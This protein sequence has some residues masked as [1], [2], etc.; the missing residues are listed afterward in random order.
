[1]KLILFLLI[2]SSQIS[3]ATNTL[4]GDDLILRHAESIGSNTTPSSKSVLDLTSTT[5]GLLAPRMTTVQQ[6]AIT[7]VPEGLLLFDSTLHR[8]AYYNASAWLNLS[9]LTGTETLTNKTLTT[10]TLDIISATE[11]SGVPSTPSAGTKKIYCKNDDTCYTL[12]SSGSEVALGSGSGGGGI[13]DRELITNNGAETA[14]TGFTAYADAAGIAPVDGT[15]GSPTFTWTRTTSSPITGS[16]SFLATKD[17]AN[18][19]G[20]GASYAF[21]VG[22]A[23]QAKVLQ[24]EFDYLV[25]SGAF[26]AGSA[27]VDSDIEVYIYDVTNSTLIQ[28]SSYKLLSTS[29]TINSHFT[30]NFQ[31]S[32]TGTSYRLIFHT[33][34][35]SAS[36]YTVK[37]DN[38]SVHS[39]KYTYGTPITDWITFTASISSTG[40]GSPA[41]GTNTQ[42]AM[43]RRVG[44]SMHIRWNVRQTAT[45]TTGT[46]G[47]YLLLIPGGYSIDTSKVTLDTTGANGYGIGEAH[48]KCAASSNTGGNAVIPYNST[49]LATQYSNVSG[50]LW[51]TGS[52]GCILGSSADV[53]IYLEAHIPIS[54]WSATVQM[55]DTGGD[56]RVV[57]ARVSGDPASATSGNI[58]IFPTADFDTHGAY[59]TTTGRFTCPVSGYYRV[60]VVAMTPTASIG[61]FVYKNAV[62]NVQLGTTE[63]DLGDLTSSTI[64][65][66]N[67]GDILDLRPNGTNNLD[68][69]SSMAYEK[70]GGPAT[71]AATETIAARYFASGTSIN[72]SL[73]TI[74]WT[75]KDYDTHGGMSAGTYTVP[76]VGKY[77]VSCA[78]A[79]SGTHALN[80]QTIIEIQKNGT[81]TKNVT[82]YSAAAVTN[83]NVEIVDVVNASAGDTIRC[84][85]SSAATGPAI[86]SSNTRNVITIHRIGL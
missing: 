82:H 30:A 60:S 20:E 26:V 84:Q 38:I 16:G 67:A 35:T 8:P 17:A 55:S 71:I 10:P 49:H 61:L 36:A 72:G 5:R 70:V 80:T 32:A 76:A 23:D 40:G 46:A 81:A 47:T 33:A 57:A 68:S 58:I 21:T 56:G 18:R 1:M 62:S 13:N 83:E 66:C 25:G 73:A 11:Q 43:W 24:I 9:S 22:T 50:T 2:L 3:H 48:F 52:T 28:P 77:S 39:S 63:T 29:T 14:T 19:Q 51:G 75:T 85:L 78:V 64:V 42:T 34:T 7:S 31:T 12:N 6:N 37:F 54:G 86:V 53:Q 74:S 4:R 45:G 15:A 59:N 79:T 44:D 41:F 27:G 65:Q 69:T